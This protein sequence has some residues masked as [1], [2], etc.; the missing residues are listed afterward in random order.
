MT[1]SPKLLT[2]A[3]AALALATPAAAQSGDARGLIARATTA[4]TTGNV[5]SARNL[6]G[7]AIAADRNSALA[8]ALAGRIALSQGD[9][10]GGEAALRRAIDVGFPAARAHHLLGE[11]RLL[12]GDAAGALREARQAP[13]RYAAYGL[14]V[15]A[16]ALAA[17]GNPPAGDALLREATE[18]APKS[19][20]AWSDYAGFSHSLGDIVGAIAKADRALALDPDN[21]D[22]LLLRG[23]LVRTQF[24]LNAALPWFEAV[25]KRDPNHYDALI[26]YAATLGDLGRASDMLSATRRALAVKPGSP[27]GLYLLAV[28]AARA[29]RVD[30]ARGLLERGWGALDGIPGPL[31]LAATLDVQAGDYQQAI[32]KLRNLVAIQP[33][34]VRARQLLGLALLRSGGARDAL[35]VLR[36]VALRGDADSY[37]LTLV[38]RAFEATG[39]RGWAAR[40]LDRAAFPARSGATTFGSDVGVAVLAAAAD[41]VPA[42]DPTGSIPLIRGLLDAGQGDRALAE[43]RKVAAASP[44]APQAIIVLGDTLMELGRAGEAADVYRRAASIAFDEPTMLRLIEALEGAG[45]RAE[46]ARALAL[47]LSQNPA[48]IPGQRLAAHWQIAA[49]DYDAA[50]DVLEG[51]RARIGNRDAALLAELALAYDGAGEDKAARSYAAAA[52]ALAPGNPAT[53]DAYGWMLHGA[54]DFDGARQLIEKAVMIAPAHPT[55]RWHLAQVYA[56]LGR[57]GAAAQQARLALGSPAFAEREAAQSL[58]DAQG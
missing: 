2:A 5:T 30:L 27:Q 57:G 31:I 45:R 34:N 51:L 19:S 46:A 52:Y 58:I 47:F 20:R 35:D 6:A 42:G 33:M 13:P 23:R 14:G 37:T 12:Q 41:K 8:H 39:E 38:A 49:G 24:G 50:I 44:G 11:A 55:L 1:F 29:D 9:G 4:F 26:D 43:A 16:R 53:A 7:A 17:M 48:S 10:V 28:L 22:A 54:G 56:A 18:S 40:Y 3:S 32:R 36:P 15:Q 21:V 25:L